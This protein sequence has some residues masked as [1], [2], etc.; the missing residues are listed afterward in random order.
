MLTKKFTSMKNNFQPVQITRFGLLGLYC[1]YVVYCV[2]L[3]I[4]LHN[5]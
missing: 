3:F 1:L 5:K 2:F 4:C